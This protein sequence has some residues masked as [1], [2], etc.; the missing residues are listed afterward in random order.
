[1]TRK[2]RKRATVGPHPLIQPLREFLDSLPSRADRELL[3][4]HL[5]SVISFLRDAQSRLDQ[6]P[7]REGY[8]RIEESLALLDGMFAKARE[9]AALAMTLGIKPAMPRRTRQVPAI[10]DE[11]AKALLARVQDLPIDHLRRELARSESESPGAARALAKQLGIRVDRRTA[12]D[13]LLQRISMKITNARG[14]R[15]LREGNE[16][17]SVDESFPKNP[18]Y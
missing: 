12:V 1:M 3:R 17:S 7:V 14:Y 6:L 15:A 11:K 2:T 18:E 16:P 8:G 13:D 10:D 9:N 5:N 4:S